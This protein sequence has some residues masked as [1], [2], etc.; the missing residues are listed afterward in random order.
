MVELTLRWKRCWMRC[1]LESTSFGVKN[2]Q[3]IQ[4][5]STCLI[6]IRVRGLFRFLRAA[7]LLR[8]RAMKTES[9]AMAPLY[10]HKPLNYLTEQLIPP[11]LP[12]SMPHFLPP[13]PSSFPF[14][15]GLV[16][17]PLPNGRNVSET[18]RSGSRGSARK[19]RH[20]RCKAWLCD[21][22]GINGI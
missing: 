19:A 7:C 13:L 20:Q 6:C 21:P 4:N 22:P 11:C 18:S 16:C 15:A 10:K 12:P 17:S 8:L 3:R 14:L 5:R 2:M 9:M 1:A